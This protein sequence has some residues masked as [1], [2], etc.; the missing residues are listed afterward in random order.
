MTLGT[1]TSLL[2]TQVRIFYSFSPLPLLSAQRIPFFVLLLPFL[3][4]LLAARALL[5]RNKSSFQTNVTGPDT[6]SLHTDTP[7]LTPDSST[8]TGLLSSTSFSTSF[9]HVVP[10]Y[11][12]CTLDSSVGM[13]G[14]FRVE[15]NDN[16]KILYTSPQPLGSKGKE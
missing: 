1:H 3:C 15:S 9:E 16:D 7:T 13:F 11:V 5:F 2:N 12:A 6:A 4:L 10:F 8:K 14:E